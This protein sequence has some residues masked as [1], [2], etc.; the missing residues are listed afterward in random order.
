MGIILK[1]SDLEWTNDWI[2]ILL[3]YNLLIDS[4]FGITFKEIKHN[5]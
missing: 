2:F 4:F 1:F 5:F 3:D